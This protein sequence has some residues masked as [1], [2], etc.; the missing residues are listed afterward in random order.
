MPK[1]E[2]ARAGG[3][4]TKVIKIGKAQGILLPREFRVAVGKVYLKKVPEGFIVM[5]RDPWEIC[6]K[7]CQELS[8]DFMKERKQPRGQ[9]RIWT[10]VFR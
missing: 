5:E 2:N 6:R 8:G 1:V 4:L 3:V 10:G 7:A 9:D